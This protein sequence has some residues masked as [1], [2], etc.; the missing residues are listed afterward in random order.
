MR[1]APLALVAATTLAVPGVA[2]SSPLVHPPRMVEGPPLRPPWGGPL[3]ETCVPPGK[4]R[5]V[6]LTMHGGA[7]SV[8]DGPG[9]LRVSEALKR[10]MCSRGLV[11]YNCDYGAGGPGL[12]GLERMYDLIKRR[13]PLLPIGAAGESSGG[14]LAMMLAR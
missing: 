1:L 14:H 4:P 3:Y 5:G 9:A 11:T 7:W 6:I 13:R 8:T 2:H 10:R 12:A